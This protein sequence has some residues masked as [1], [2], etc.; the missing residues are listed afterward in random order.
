MKHRF[1]AGTL[2]TLAISLLLAHAPMAQAVQPAAK[3]ASHR[4]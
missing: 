2:G 1:A 3:A 4:P